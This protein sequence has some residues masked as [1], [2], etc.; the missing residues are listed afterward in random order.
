MKNKHHAHLMLINK[1]IT[2]NLRIAFLQAGVHI[3]DMSNLSESGFTIV[4]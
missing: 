2:K 4:I 3:M 1:V